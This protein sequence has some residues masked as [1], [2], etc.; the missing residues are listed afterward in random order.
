MCP[1]KKSWFLSLWQCGLK[2]SFKFSPDTA[3]THTFYINICKK[4][5]KMFG[6]GVDFKFN[7]IIYYYFVL[8]LYFLRVS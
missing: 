8:E 5:K 7:V 4:K 2:A 1:V 3:C 6:G